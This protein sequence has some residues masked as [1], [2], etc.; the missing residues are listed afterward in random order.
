MLLKSTPEGAREFLVP[1]RLGFLDP[2]SAA[3]SSSPSPTPSPPPPAVAAA[4][5]P[6]V[7]PPVR[8]TTH[9]T[10][11]IPDG[12]LAAELT[13]APPPAPTETPSPPPPSSSAS[14][15]TQPLFYALPQ[16]PQQ[17]KQLLIASGAVE[18]YYQIARCFRDEDGRR[19]RQPEFTQIDLE[20][21][22]VSWGA[23]GATTEAGRGAVDAVPAAEDPAADSALAPAADSGLGD[24]ANETATEKKSAA[25]ESEGDG[26]RIGGT[27][28]RDVV[29]T[30]VRTIW[31]KAE[32]VVLPARFP[33]MR[34]ADAMARF[35]SDKPDTRFGLEVR[36]TGVPCTCRKL[37]YGSLSA[38]SS[39]WSRSVRV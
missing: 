24:D 30:L 31:E 36:L 12:P 18:R 21:A 28:V 9:E 39:L 38:L 23:P 2:T 35:G 7:Q 10:F 22:W 29:E 32:G 3:Q 8:P 6:W 25:V 27:E 37:I 4:S 34:Y 13:E 19:D 26:W 14:V 1:T 15:P 20:M 5:S 33:V 16:S 17:P 11:E